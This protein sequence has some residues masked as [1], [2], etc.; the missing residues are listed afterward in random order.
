MAK[1]ILFLL[2]LPTLLFSDLEKINLQLQWK[3][4]F[5]FAGFYAAQEKGF[6]KD[7][8]LDVHFLEYGK[9]KTILEEVLSGRAQYGILYS[10]LIAD[11][12]NDEPVVFVANFFKQSPL[13]LVAQENIKTPAD[14][15]GKTV[16]G[17][18]DHIQGIT[19]L[20]MFKTFNIG[21][22]DITNVQSTFN[23]DDFIN[24]KV[25][26]MAVFTTNEPY[27]LNKKGIKYN[28][29]D[30]T[31]YG[32]KY[33][34]V[35]LFTSKKELEEHPL[36][37]KNFKEASIKG[38]EYALSH[39]EEMIALILKKYNTQ[40]KTKEAYQFEANQIEQIMLPN[41][42]PI[43]S[44]DPERVKTIAERFVQFGFC[45]HAATEEQLESFIYNPHAKKPSLTPQEAEYLKNKKEIKI[46]ID[47]DWMPFEANKDARH[48][49]ISAD[50]FKLFEK[51]LHIPIVLVDTKNWSES[52]DFAKQ[53]KCDVLPLIMS[54]PQRELY[55][56]F[57]SPYL[58]VPLVL[59]TKLDVTFVTDINTL[60]NEKVAIPKDYAFNE[61]LR[62]K[63][64][65]L[66]IVDVQNIQEG[67][68]LVRRGKVFGYVGTLASVGYM[69]Q[70]AYTGELKIAGKFD[71]N[72]K[73]G[74]GVRND[75]PMLFQLMQ[76]A[77]D[78]ISEDE[79]QT[80]LNKWV[81]VKYERGIDYTL[82]WQILGVSLFI[83]IGAFYWNRR[84]S[85]LNKELE[86]AKLKAEEATKVKSNFLANMSHEIRTPMNAIVGMSYLIKETNLSPSQH[87]YIQK[88][89]TA[90][91]NLLNL[92]NDI[93]DF[94]KI[95]AR[96]MKVHA[97]D[98]NLIEILQNVENIVK[99]KADENGIEYKTNY[100]ASMPTNLHGDSLRL[101]QVL[102][103]LASNAV[104][105]THAG[106]VELLASYISGDTFR[107]EISDTG[108]GIEKEQIEKLFSSFTQADESTTRKY[109]GTGLGLA[110]SKELVELM[111]GKI[112]VQSTLGQGSKFIF[113]IKFK[114]THESQKNETIKNKALV[115]PQT[116]PHADK[117]LITQQDRDILFDALQKSV[118]K[119]RP[120]LCKP[121]LE[122]IELYTLSTEDEKLFIELKSYIKRYKFKEAIELL[123]AK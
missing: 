14:L 109:G 36:R 112:W 105:F 92:L 66:Q 69:F 123:G 106:K 93:L 32:N 102:L 31:V 95:E 62:T 107:F 48:V 101:S 71:E 65:Y 6:Y 67:L 40:N 108:I 88:L 23:N 63:Y 45:K 122:Q 9:E 51:N 41:V 82:A 50:Y 117:P 68:D 78:S 113:E 104:K 8:G 28:V 119:R 1:L 17:V 35:N 26:A 37:V 20:S 97:V 34:D 44:I 52:L 55:L 22:N 54:T 12:L 56:R 111:G 75:D 49:G 90:S 83:L 15:K 99:I 85:F 13:V 10:S 59:A 25:D 81:A 18:S 76:K 87:Q 46:C 58:K 118:V 98:F 47:P 74:I 27:E 7:V 29:L 94:S 96:K 116:I 79:R 38:W 91:N 110:I 57:T 2:L 103:N 53:K 3:H 80:I 114:H 11:F 115:Q 42:Y 121:V 77:V 86:S 120:R 21:L 5:E 30:P 61:L 33:Y 4:Q 24:K 73:L 84:L 70:T 19:L 72:W 39:K 43:G 100:D 89:E 60:K 64:P 16:M